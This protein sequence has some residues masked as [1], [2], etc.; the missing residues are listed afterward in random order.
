MYNKKVGNS[1]I[2]Y[3]LNPVPLHEFVWRV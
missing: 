2:I 1:K 3:I